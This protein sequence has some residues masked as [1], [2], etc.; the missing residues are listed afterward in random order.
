V[1]VT[2]HAVLRWECPYRSSAVTAALY[3]SD[4]AELIGNTLAG[5]NA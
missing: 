3:P 1:R 5:Q 2:G 4:I